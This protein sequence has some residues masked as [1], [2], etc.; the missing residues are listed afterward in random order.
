MT[1]QVVVSTISQVTNELVKLIVISTEFSCLDH[2]IYFSQLSS[3]IVAL[4]FMIHLD[5]GL[6]NTFNIKAEDKHVFFTNFLSNLNVGSI[7]GSYDKTAIHDKFHVRGTRGFGSCSRN[8][9]R[10]LC[11]WDNCLG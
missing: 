2:F 6:I 5:P 8:V 1:D 11:C 7:H 9:L 3:I 10:K 4:V